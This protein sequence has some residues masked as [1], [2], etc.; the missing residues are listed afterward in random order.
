MFRY[1]I[2]LL[3]LLALAAPAH[4]QRRTVTHDTAGAFADAGAAVLLNRAR[5]ARLRSD[6]SIRSYTAVIRARM[7]A[8]M[9]MPL[10]DRTLARQEMASRVRWS[11]DA[12]TVVQRLAGRDQNPGGVE[13]S[14]ARGLT[15]TN[16]YDPATDR[17]Y[18]GL[19]IEDDSADGDEEFWLEHPLG[20]HAEQHYRYESG[21]TLRITLQDGTVIRAIEL[22]VTPKRDDP[23]TLRGLLWVDPSTGVVSQAAFRLARTVDILQDFEFGDPDAEKAMRRMPGFLKPFA[24]DITLMTVEYSLW[25]L[26]Y[27]MPRTTRFDG[28][29]RAGVVQFPAAF[30]ISYDIEE[31]ETDEDGRTTDEAAR[32][33]RVAEEWAAAG[34]FRREVIERD[35]ARNRHRGYIILSPPD[36]VL[37][38]SPQLPPA[39]WKDA[40]GFATEDELERMADRLKDLAG[41]I[42][43][44]A[45]TTHFGWGIG[46]PDMVRYNRVEALSIG[47]RGTLSLPLVDARATV[48]LGAGDLHPNAELALLHFSPK[49]TLILRGYHELSTADE[50]R[51]ALG[52]GNSLASLLLGR[53]EGEYYR[54]SG[55][56]FTWAPPTESRRSW[57]ITTYGEYQNDVERHTHIA[58]PRLWDDSVF[59]SNI[60]ADEAFQYGGMLRWRP[61]WGT[62]P[63]RTQ[64]G[65]DAMLQGELGDFEFG[66]ARLTLRTALPLFAGARMA[67][68]A[69]AGTTEGDVPVQRFFYLG[70]ASTLRGYEPSVVSGTSMARG[71]LEIA[72]SWP[73]ANFVVFGDWG[74]AG[75]RDDWRGYDEK[76]AAGAGFSLL[77]GVIRLDL[78]RALRSPK[79]W[80]LDL[81]LDAIM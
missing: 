31:I 72:R 56:S 17:M 46:E 45:G 36:S 43:R 74:W 6:S 25:D 71:R 49:R 5:D 70:G 15:V 8:G 12:Q 23:H 9:R 28:S 7:A 65:V 73:F 68:E 52:L 22:R 69:G 47:A 59:R 18:F 39:I 77:D 30:E 34:E 16:L 40:P 32:A 67:I 35:T 41:P 24:F 61:W 13:A 44:P 60:V 51:R 76:L 54:A 19:G 2:C 42:L 62:D 66:R 4:A 38:S 75:D 53:D 80:R 26:K 64:F 27:W 81:H 48:R 79:G 58:L 33:L 21:D 10:K 55:A 14:G 50:S 20:A 11:R 1:L 63:T 3:V 29:I 57:D 37:I 78:A